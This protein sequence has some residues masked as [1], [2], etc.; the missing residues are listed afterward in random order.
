MPLVI[1]VHADGED[2]III[3]HGGETLV[4][5]V[6]IEEKQAKVLLTSPKSF[7]IVRGKVLERKNRWTG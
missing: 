3:T 4:V 6:A 2:S 5:S 1:K 7:G